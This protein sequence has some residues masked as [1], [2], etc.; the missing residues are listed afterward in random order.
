[1]LLFAPVTGVVLFVLSIFAMLANVHEV[2]YLHLLPL[3]FIA[4]HRCFVYFFMHKKYIRTKAVLRE[5]YIALFLFHFAYFY[6]LETKWILP[7]AVNEVNIIFA[8]TIS[9]ESPSSEDDNIAK[10]IRGASFS[11]NWKQLKKVFMSQRF[12]F[13]LSFLNTYSMWQLLT[14]CRFYLIFP[15]LHFQVCCKFTSIHKVKK[16]TL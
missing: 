6:L 13:L 12:F 14:W 1:M 10:D 9:M 7:L 4:E 5:A 2:F 15:G 11:S 8:G 3:Q 16:T